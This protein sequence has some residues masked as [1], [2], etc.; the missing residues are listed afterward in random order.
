MAADTQGND[1][2]SVNVPVTGR[3][4]VVPYEEENVITP[5]MIG[6][7][8][9]EPDLPE[10]YA[11]GAIGLVTSDGAPQDS[12]ETGDA[13]EF[14]QQG[15]QVNGEASITTAFTAAEDNAVTRRFVNGSDPDEH[16][17][18]GIDTLTPDGKWMAYYEE[19]YKNGRVYRRAGVVTLTGNEPGQSTRGSVKGRALTVTWQ[20]DDYYGGHK[21]IESTYEP[22]A[23]G[24]T[25]STREAGQ[26]G[27]TG[28]TGQ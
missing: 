3:I 22:A 9:E 10:A 24:T 26:T 6:E 27:S 17:V 20:N 7:D 16:G 2:E 25:G 15:Y 28:Q 14:W 18:Y 4:S 12:S 8:V 19:A 13:T 21:Y 11:T 23:S 1:L 5:E